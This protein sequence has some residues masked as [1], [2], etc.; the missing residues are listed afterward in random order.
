MATA[1]RTFFHDYPN[2][3]A[4]GVHDLSGNELKI[5]LSNTAPTA[6]TDTVIAD[7]T[8][9]AAGNG[10]TAGGFVLANRTFT[11]VGGLV[12]VDFDDIQIDAAGGD[13]GPFRYPILYNNTPTSPVDPLI[14]FYDIGEVVTVLDG[15]S[16]QLRLNASGLLTINLPA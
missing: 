14:C 2:R 12:T 10:Y 16:Y 15:A 6:A 3:L 4:R 13:I 8:E 5:L 9:I 7:I 11:A 1:T